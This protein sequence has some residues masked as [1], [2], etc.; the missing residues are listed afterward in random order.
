MTPSRTRQLSECPDPR[1]ITN[2]VAARRSA[3]SKVQPDAT[4]NR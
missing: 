2:R 1:A 4:K 3:S